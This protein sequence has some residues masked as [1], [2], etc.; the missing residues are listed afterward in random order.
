MTQRAHVRKFVESL[1]TRACAIADEYVLDFCKNHG[2]EAGASK[3]VPPSNPVMRDIV[4]ALENASSL[5]TAIDRL[6]LL[7]GPAMMHNQSN[8]ALMVASGAFFSADPQG[9]LSRWF[10][11]DVLPAAIEELLKSAHCSNH[12]IWSPSGPADAPA[13]RA[14]NWKV[15]AFVYIGAA[16]LSGFLI[17]SR[18]DPAT[19]IAAD[20]IFALSLG[21][22]RIVGSN[23]SH[24]I[25]F[26]MGGPLLAAIATISWAR[27]RASLAGSALTMSWKGFALLGIAISTMGLAGMWE[28]ASRKQNTRTIEQE[29]GGDGTAVIRPQQPTS[30]LSPPSPPPFPETETTGYSAGRQA[31]ERGDY[32]LAM[33]LLQSAARDR[34]DH[35]AYVGSNYLVGLMLLKGQGVSKDPATAFHWFKAAA[36][37][38]HPQSQFE[39]GWMVHSGLGVTKDQAAAVKWWRLAAQ[40]GYVQAQHVL[41][42]ALATGRGIA[43]DDAEAVKWFRL[44]AEKSHAPSQ[45]NLGIM[46]ASGRGVPKNEAEAVQWF[47]AA[48]EKGHAHGQYQLGRSLLRGAGVAKNFT[49]GLAWLAKAAE[50]GH[51]GAR[52]EI[53]RIEAERKTKPKIETS[54]I[55]SS[56]GTIVKTQ[57]SPILGKWQGSYACQQGETGLRLTIWSEQENGTRLKALFEFFPLATNPRVPSGSLVLAGA[58]ESASRRLVLQPAYWRDQPPGYKAVGIDVQLDGGVLT[59]RVVAPGCQWIKVEKEKGW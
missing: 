17:P 31:H 26:G 54:S 40:K 42:V 1:F 10:S 36:D 14:I 30:L 18:R 51:E 45:V 2:G 32:P 53:A 35:R 4:A 29:R 47:R 12:Q 22:Y 44:G 7:F 13:L 39:L 11:Y 41:G 57:T 56:K 55:D 19:T 52:K 49:E 23:I 28:N 33:Q 8:H 34:S 50:T 38:G 48:A 43:K 15:I 5:A 21:Y 9:Y 20:T 3:V 24:V 59:G 6:K 25:G 16:M 37:H 46:L 27:I 58:F